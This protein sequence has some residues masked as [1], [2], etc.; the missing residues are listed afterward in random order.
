M[1]GAVP[2]PLWRTVRTNPPTEADFLS[3]KA[4][5]LARRSGPIEQWEG[6][7]TFDNPAIAADMARR[8]H[9]GD[10]LARLDLDPA[11]PIRWEKTRGAGHYTIW[12]TPAELLARV[13][14][15]VPLDTAEEEAQ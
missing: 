6:V 1:S 2:P 15:I 14:E 11:G 9:Q 7:S 8:H 12:G 5:G 3:F 10:Y 4:R 13:V